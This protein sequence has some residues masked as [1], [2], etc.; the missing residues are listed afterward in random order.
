MTQVHCQKSCTQT[1]CPACF[2]QRN[3]HK[4]HEQFP[5]LEVDSQSETFAFGCS[6]CRE[7][8]G[9]TAAQKST[10]AG[11]S[12]RRLAVTSYHA[13]QVRPLEDHADSKNHVQAMKL[14]PSCPETSP[15]IEH[16]KKLL[17][18]MK[19]SPIGTDGFSEVG[20]QKKC[21]KMAWAIAEA[22]RQLKREV[23]LKKTG[24]DGTP[25]VTSATLFQD[26]RHGRLSVRCTVATSAGERISGHIGTVNLGE[27]ADATSLMEATMS[28]LQMFC[29][30]SFHPPHV[31]A[32]Q[33]VSMDS[34]L[35]ARVKNSIECFVSDSAS[36][37]LRS[38][39]ML[40]GQ[41]TTTAY[42]PKLPSLKVVMRDRPHATRRCISRN[43]RADPFLQ[44]V[45]D[46]FLFAADSPVRLV[47]NS[48]IFKSWFANNIQRLEA[49][50][51]A[52]KS[53][54]HVKDLGFAPHRFESAA[55]PLSRVVLFFHPFLQT[56]SRIA[57]ERKNEESGR[58]ALRFLRWLNCE[59]CLQLAM[60]GD[61]ATETLELTRLVDYEGF[62]VD[63][64]PCQILSFRDRIRTLFTGDS[65]AC[66]AT[67][68]TA[69]MRKILQKPFCIT[70]SWNAGLET[71]H[72]G[73][74]Q[75]SE[76][77]VQSCCQRMA[78]WVRLTEQTLATE[79]PSFEVHQSFSIFSVAGLGR[80][81][82]SGVHLSTS[83]HLS[84]LLHAFK[85]PDVPACSQQLQRLWFVA[86]RSADDEKVESVEAWRRAAKQVSRTW[87]RM[88]ISA[89]LPLLVR[90][91]AAGGS[92]SGVEQAFSRAKSLTD[93][94]QI[95][96][97]VN[98]VMEVFAADL[99]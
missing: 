85:L 12:W 47:C 5:W 16:F 73:Q 9:N 25:L 65:P 57:A 60:L 4:L 34:D 55:K 87:S 64:L 99:F 62:P 78:A 58:A 13:L 56:L 43:W 29:T 95:I 14:D 2:F 81:T 67:G 44:E 54:A 80:P 94:L 68:L 20:G 38:G 76:V 1:R 96:G 86:R 89:A 33:V 19:K 23:W 21:R 63:E 72:I 74:P 53:H 69:H 88:Q 91:W 50:M 98:D 11:G 66:L 10:S 22:S 30:P 7:A 35:F 36:D 97:H 37:E 24:L 70:V 3:E 18:H 51:S 15:S 32:P 77:L 39:F 17:K 6:I 75:M 31:E 45:A 49:S 41:S 40:A 59:R 61:C 48:H 92:T 90:F 42:L 83:S 26:A 79:F 8:F 71:F 82:D 93:N 27:S 28:V 46:A 84:K 52:V